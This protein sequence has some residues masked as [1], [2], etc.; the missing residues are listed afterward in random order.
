M[1]ENDLY[2]VYY[3]WLE[4]YFYTG[5]ILAILLY[6]HPLLIAPIGLL[7]SYKTRKNLD[8]Y[9]RITLS[10]LVS[11]YVLIQYN[12]HVADANFLMI[13][14]TNIIYFVACMFLMD[15]YKKGRSIWK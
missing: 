14:S 3:R 10:Y 1:K 6:I 13:T 8:K 15:E 12:Q 5:L 2:I 4:Y 7:L 11:T 9:Y